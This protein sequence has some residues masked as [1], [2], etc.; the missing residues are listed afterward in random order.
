MKK[1]YLGYRGGAQVF[2]QIPKEERK[3]LP[4]YFFIE[5]DLDTIKERKKGEKIEETKIN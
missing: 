5:V 4:A 1:K 2:V 3:N